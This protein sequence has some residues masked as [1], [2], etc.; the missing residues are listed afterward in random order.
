VD[1]LVTARPAGAP[2]VEIKN[3]GQ[4]PGRRQRHELAAVFKP[5]ALNDSVKQIGLQPGDDVFKAWRGQNTIEQMTSVCR[6]ASCW[7]VAGPI[8]SFGTRGVRLPAAR[9]ARASTIYGFRH[10]PPQFL[11]WSATNSGQHW[12]SSPR[13]KAARAAARLCRT[14]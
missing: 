4:L 2:Q 7:L 5:A 14:P 8:G 11:R 9:T 1:L 3:A 6:M 10:K 13:V 12:Q